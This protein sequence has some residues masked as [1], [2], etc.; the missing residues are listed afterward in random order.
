MI[1][2]RETKK[3]KFRFVAR[4]LVELSKKKINGKF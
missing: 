2:T 3:K 1:K 4:K